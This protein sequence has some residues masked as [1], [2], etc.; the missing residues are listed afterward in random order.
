VSTLIIRHGM[1]FI[2]DFAKKDP[3]LLLGTEL[4]GKGLIAWTNGVFDF[5]THAL[6]LFSLDIV[7]FLLGGAQLTNNR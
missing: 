6:L 4:S 2:R 7:F 3:R 5:R 1:D